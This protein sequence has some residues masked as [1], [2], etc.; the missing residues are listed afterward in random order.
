MLDFKIVDMKRHSSGFGVATVLSFRDQQEHTV[1]NRYGSWM[2]G[3]PE[4][5]GVMRETAT[6]SSALAGWLQDRW[7]DEKQPLPNMDAPAPVNPF[8]RKAAKK[9]P[10]IAKLL[11]AGK[12]S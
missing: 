4:V 11:A 12:I 5:R 1:H 6:I 2:I 9:N 7:T 8:I 10:M 3:D